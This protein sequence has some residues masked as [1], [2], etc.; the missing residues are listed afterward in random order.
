MCSTATHRG[1]FVWSQVSHFLSLGCLFVVW[2]VILLTCVT[3]CHPVCH[4]HSLGWIHIISG[5]PLLLTGMASCHSRCSIFAHWVAP[6]HFRCLTAAKCVGSLWS[7]VSNYH[8]L[9]RLHVAPGA[10][11]LSLWLLCIILNVSLL[12]TEVPSCHSVCSTAAY[13]EGSVP[14]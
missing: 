2:T 6:C 10:Y 12:L 11:S 5:V 14:F 7:W 4:C 3:L 1:N 13:L 8:S 9:G